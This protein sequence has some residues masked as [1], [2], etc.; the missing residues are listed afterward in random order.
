MRT[1][2]PGESATV[3]LCPVRD[4]AAPL[5]REDR[6]L[7][8]PRQHTFDVARSGYVNL[9]QPQDRRSARPGDSAA[10]LEARRRLL[11]RGL[12]TP[13]IAAMLE[14]PSLAPT[15]A[16]L[17]VGCGEGTHLAAIA[18]R[19]GCEGH[20]V[21]ISVTAIDSAA[22]RHPGLSWVVANADR[23]LPYAA[24]SFRLVASITARRNAVEF[25]RILR[26]DGAVLLVVPAPDDLVELREAVLGEGTARDRLPAALDALV[27]L[28]VLERHERVRHAARLDR[29]AIEDQMIASYRALRRSQRARLANLDDIDVT[30]SRDLLLLRPAR[31][32]TISA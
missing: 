5:T 9:L 26:D 3:L 15:D 16:V 28:F 1:S 32:A 12:E 31:H 20:G 24:A 6:R 8:C 4:C 23:R 11:G 27:P 25:R 2:S 13:F 30:F 19:F 7:R 22:R 10:T 29:A 14:M 18:E 17:E 21:D